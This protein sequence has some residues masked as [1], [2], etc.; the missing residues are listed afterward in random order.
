MLKAI[1]NENLNWEAYYNINKQR[2]QKKNI[3]KEENVARKARNFTS[4]TKDL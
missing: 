1:K 2:K 3:I 4:K